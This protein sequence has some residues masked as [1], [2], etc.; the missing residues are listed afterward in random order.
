MIAAR[1][2]LSV[3]QKRLAM[4]ALGLIEEGGNELLPDPAPMRPGSEREDGG[5]L[6]WAGSPHRRGHYAARRAAVASP[7]VP[8]DTGSGPVVAP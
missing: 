7:E 5:H 2:D 3:A 8:R 4:E 6:R 1:R